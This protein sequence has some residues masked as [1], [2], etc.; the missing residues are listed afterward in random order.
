[1]PK[2]RI[3]AEK[4]GRLSVPSVDYVYYSATFPRFAVDR[5]HSTTIR[6]RGF[7]TDAMF[8]YELASQESTNGG[9]TSIERRVPWL[10]AVLRIVAKDLDSRIFHSR[11]LRSQRPELGFL[12]YASEP[13][14]RRQYD[15]YSA[16][17][18]SRR[19]R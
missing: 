10:K 5:R 12:L 13:A 3:C 6:V 17:E 1:M 18:R 9:F 14:A 4:L 16:F 11:P 2:S 15:D 7:P 19:A 8:F